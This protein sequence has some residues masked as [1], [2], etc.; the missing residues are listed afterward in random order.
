MPPIA[1]SVSSNCPL[2]GGKATLFEGGV[3]VSETVES[4]DVFPT[5]LD[6][7]GLERPPVTTPQDEVDGA[8]LLPLMRGGS[9]GVR[10]RPAEADP[11]QLRLLGL[12]PPLEPLTWTQRVRRD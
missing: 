7:M 10:L 12:P 5:V 9:L 4:I 2:R 1:D 11:E 6:A 3:R 8:T